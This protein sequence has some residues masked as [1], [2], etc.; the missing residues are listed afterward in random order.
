M[1]FWL[2][3]GAAIVFALVLL[4][5]LASWYKKVERQ[6]EV[7]IINGKMKVTA[8]FTGGIVFPI[9]NTHEYMDITRKGISV[10]RRG[11]KEGSSDEYEGLHCKDN[12]RADLK[13][14]FFIGVNPDEKDIL[15]VVKTF[16]A[17]QA[18]D[19][20]YLKKYFTPKFS[21]ALKTAVK[22]FE[23]EELLTKRQ[24]FREEVKKVIKDDL[25]G[26]K[27]YDV[28]IDRIDQ[29][30][31]EAHDPN[32]ILDV[33]GIEK[34]AK[35]T[36]TKNIETNII[37]QDEQTSIKK[38][39]VEAEEARLQLD[40]KEAEA[41]AKKEREV[42]VIQ[43][44]ER[45]MTKEK[46]EQYRLQE[47]RARIKSDEEIAIEEENKN[48]EV[49]IARINNERVTEIEQEKVN[50]AKETEKV[51]TDREVSVRNM[52]KEKVLEEQKKEVAETRSV[53]VQIERKIAKEEEETENLRARESAN[54]KKVVEVTAAESVAE[55]KQIEK[56]KE[57]EAQR[58]AAELQGE[59][60]TIQAEAEYK[61]SVK[62]AEAKERIADATQKAAAAEGLAQARV[63]IEMA[64]A[65]R[66]K[67]RAEAESAEALGI[68]QAKGEEA[69]YEAMSKID[70][71]SREH[72][73]FKLE[74][75]NEREIAIARI[76]KDAKVA[77]E[78]AR[79]LSAAMSKADMK[80][81]GDADI[82]TQVKNAMISGQ[83]FDEKFNNSEILNSLVKDYRNG[84]KSLSDDLK[85]VLQ[86]SEVSTGDVS[87]LMLA[88]AL[89]KL[90][91][92]PKN[93]GLLEG[94]LGSVKKD[95]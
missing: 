69:R 4:G 38:K 44:Q 29:T 80:I 18:S 26:F 71:E 20:A 22:Q 34:I 90:A 31:L 67:G 86:K 75:E 48:R 92:D 52:E 95:S 30:A 19:E 27:L 88:Q 2:Y 70:S 10:E 64:E 94:F 84:S 72:D 79:V 85:E 14:D 56:V 16:T 91:S 6:G 76:E 32:N 25:D 51:E 89:T 93:A 12:I 73:K 57:A 87:S 42:A 62:E 23:F 53:R 60:I 17:K 3:V 43:A 68:A 47:E 40:K 66:Q 83:A 50:R 49:E 8:T 65:I 1:E 58:K 36:S 9:I 21:E 41:I 28:V 13:V 46:S 45:A 55:A 78:N 15:N 59:T 82:F 39:Q 54:R 61:K 37:R 33:E 11:Q 81:F 74:L 77:E 63:E 5:V 35:R 24:E 7:L